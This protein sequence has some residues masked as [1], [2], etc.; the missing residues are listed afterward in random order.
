M[1]DV[2]GN[3]PALDACLAHAER[4]GCEHLLVL[5]DVVGY[6]DDGIA[7]LDRLRSVGASFLRGNH[8][9]ML[10]GDLDVPAGAESVYRLSE[11]RE[12]LSAEQRRFLAGLEPRREL[13]LGGRR[14]LLVH[15][16]PDDP[17][18]GYA[19]PDGDLAA[20]EN[21]TFDYVVMGNTHR[22]MLRKAGQVTVVNV[23]S[24]GL[25]RDIGSRS[26]FGVYDA[27]TDQLSIEEVPMN[28][29]LVRRNYPEAHPSVRA[30]LDRGPT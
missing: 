17:L 20:F 16:T 6:W 28:V 22:A 26:T 25:S 18:E 1:S 2:H 3:L 24:V 19:Y 30:V 12:Q 5:G 9:A 7:C 29:D 23:G 21:L 13:E 27:S 15:G 11:T 4:R 14:W 10:L 8:E